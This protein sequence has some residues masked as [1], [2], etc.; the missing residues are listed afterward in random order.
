MIVILH[1][2][3]T[4]EQIQQAAEHYP[5]FIKVTIDVVQKK[6]AI[7]GEYHFDAEQILLSEGSKQ[8]NIWGGSLD[9]ITKQLDTYAMINVRAGINPHQDIQ[10]LSL[11]KLFLSIAYETLKNYAAKPQVLS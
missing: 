8:D 3:P 10:D 5:D 9:L 2:F 1:S 6:I 4:K 7:G 11:K